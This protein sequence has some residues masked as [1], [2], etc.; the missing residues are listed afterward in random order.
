MEQESRVMKESYESRN[1][2]LDEEVKILTGN[3][4]TTTKKLKHFEDKS[5]CLPAMRKKVVEQTSIITN[6]QKKNKENV[7][8]FAGNENPN[9]KR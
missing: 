3:L 7:E 2:K 1:M 6:L 8:K 4:E 9:Q 5:S